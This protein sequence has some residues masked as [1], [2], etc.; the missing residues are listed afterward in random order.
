MKGLEFYAPGDVRY[1]TLP[2]PDLTDARDALVRVT[3][4]SI[5]GSDLHLYHGGLGSP[6]H[7]FSIGHEAIG[8]VIEIG[9][10][11]TN[12]KAGDKVM[13]PGSVGCGAC[14]PC[15]TGAINRCENGGMRVYGIGRGLGGCQTEAVVVPAADFNAYVIP[16]GVSD[17]Q[18]LMLTDS[19]PTA[20]L[21][22]V[23]ADIRPGGSVGVVGLGPIGLNAVEI[24]FV[25]G[26][27]VVYAIDLVPE[28]R[29]RAA[30]LGAIPL[31]PAVAVETVREQTR[32]RMLDS[33]IEVVGSPVTTDLAIEL[34]GQESTVAVIGAGLERYDFPLL[35]AFRK[36]LTFRPSVCSVQRYMP[37][38][39]ALVRSGRL[40]PER[41]ISH[42]M[43]LSDGAEAYRLFD[44]R[45]AGT[46]KMILE[47]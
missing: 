30:E 42:R 25:L 12:L 19:L 16:E 13:I 1:G 17:D 47:P 32:G 46:L 33:T 43:K 37:E 3:S 15:M 36:G 8:E 10:G 6:R 7:R 39:V 35:S 31:D 20:Y 18:A 40:H 29:A 26:A 4:C 28:R 41:Q 5:C 24:A 27:G 23:N 38:L 11:V 9:R 45:E 34:A 21:G 2:D 22:C 44:R 14:R